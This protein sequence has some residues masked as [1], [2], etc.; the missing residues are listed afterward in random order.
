[1]R[2]P[3]LT[4][5]ARQ[6]T[7]VPQQDGGRALDTLAGVMIRILA[8]LDRMDGANARIAQRLEA[9][10]AGN[11]RPAEKTKSGPYTRR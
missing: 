7:D 11:R 1:V 8:R 3:N 4:P 6:L 5:I 2:S 10:E 9:V